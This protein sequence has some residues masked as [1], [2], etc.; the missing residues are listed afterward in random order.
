MSDRGSGIVAIAS[1]LPEQRLTALEMCERAGVAPNALDRLYGLEEKRVAGP[2]EHPSELGLRVA[3]QALEQT[4]TRAEEL[5][6]II[7]CNASG[8][9]DYRA[10]SP[11]TRLQHELG[12]VNAFAYEVLNGCN[13]VN[14]ALQQAAMFL[15]TRQVGTCALVV[16]AERSAASLD[17][18]DARGLGIFH[19]G[20]GAAA[21][22]VRRGHPRARLGA[23]ASVTEGRL[24]DFMCVPDGGTR[25]PRVATGEGGLKVGDPLR[26]Q[27]ELGPRFISRYRDVIV[28]AIDQSGSA[29]PA[30]RWL[31]VNQTKRDL[32]AALL[33]ALTLPRER[34]VVT[35]AKWGHVGAC[36]T[37]LGL[38]RV[39]EQLEPGEVTVLA[40]AAAGFTWG[41]QA[42]LG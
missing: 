20:D 11:A 3:R 22:L 42:V 5:A 16:S 17:Y 12:A 38:E 19:L 29:L 14:L 15:A 23:Y 25:Q 28:E 6:L 30:L 1:Y 33:D 37:L 31:C 7:F 18:T 39:L 13:G 10:W 8:I 2:D 4:N 40:S 21:A 36:D 9:F 35:M 24:H 41:A 26:V 34:L 27:R 32:Q